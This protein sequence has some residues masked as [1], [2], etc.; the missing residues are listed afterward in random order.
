[1]PD[2]SASNTHQEPEAGPPGSGQPS[3]R[4]HQKR[5]SREGD[6]GADSVMPGREFGAGGQ[7]VDGPAGS[8]GAT[9]GDR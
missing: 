7:K 9:T 6:P 3:E 8:G 1:M 2:P 4:N 5:G